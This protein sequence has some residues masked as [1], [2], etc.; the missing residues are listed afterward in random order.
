MRQNQTVKEH[1]L[2]IQKCIINVTTFKEIIYFYESFDF[3]F[4]EDYNHFDIK[5]QENFLKFKKKSL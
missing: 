2:I 5:N 3:A 4:K 1:L